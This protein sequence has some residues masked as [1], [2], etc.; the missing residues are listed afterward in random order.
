MLTNPLGG[1]TLL[2]SALICLGMA[3]PVLAKRG[4]PKPVKPVSLDGTEY[5]LE[6]EQLQKEKNPI[7]MKAFVV[8]KDEKTGKELWKAELYQITYD[9]QLETDIQD[10]YGTSL[11]ATDKGL[12]VETEKSE[13]LLVDLQTHAVSVVK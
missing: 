13:K 12:L 3:T 5:R 1:S 6:Y 9:L 2:F 4:E 11:T 10:V 7:G 8:A